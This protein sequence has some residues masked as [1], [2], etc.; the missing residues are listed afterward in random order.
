MLDG[1][2]LDPYIVLG[3]PRGATAEQA[4]D[5]FRRKSLKHHPDTGGDEWA[6][7]IVVRAYQALSANAPIEEEPLARSKAS[8]EGSPMISTGAI[9]PEWPRPPARPGAPSDR[10]PSIAASNGPAWCRSRS[11]G[12]NTKR[13]T[14]SRCWMAVPATASLVGHSPCSGPI[15]RCPTTRGPCHSPIASSWPSMPGS[16]RSAVAPR[17]SRPAL[18]S[19]PAASRPGF[20]YPSGPV[21]HQA[22]KNLHTGL[23]ARG[24]GVNQWT[25]TLTIPRESPR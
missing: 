19:N 4:R 24:L 11:S 21:A 18:T 15:P 7:R 6:F 25:R 9:R 22:F 14:C 23:R 3:I 10:A 20:E 17:R 5:A 2:D 1:F 12:R 13:V 16:T 8:S